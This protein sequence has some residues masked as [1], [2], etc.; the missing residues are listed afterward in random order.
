MTILIFPLLR[1]SVPVVS[2]FAFMQN[3]DRRIN[4]AVPS[5]TGKSV[6]ADYPFDTFDED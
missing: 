5:E 1:E 4:S 6:H 3:N 2:I